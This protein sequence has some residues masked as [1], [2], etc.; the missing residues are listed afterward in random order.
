MIFWPYIKLCEKTLDADLKVTLNSSYKIFFIIDFIFKIIK[1]NSEKK[2][3]DTHVFVSNI[4][5]ISVYRVEH[6]Y[7][8]GILFKYFSYKEN[9][10]Q[11]KKK[12]E[13]K[14]KCRN[15]TM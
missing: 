5:R 15:I 10:L 8:D 2:W 14:P 6:W 13:K 12:K 9:F 11:P 4:Y 7:V 1:Y 3:S